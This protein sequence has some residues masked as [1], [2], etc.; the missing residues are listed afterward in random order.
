MKAAGVLS[1][2]VTYVN[3]SGAGQISRQTCLLQCVRPSRLKRSITISD[4]RRWTTWRWLQ[5]PLWL[6]CC[7]M[8]HL[9][10]R[11]MKAWPMA[12]PAAATTT[13]GRAALPTTRCSV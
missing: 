10:L 1:M 8:R 7:Q 11:R 12:T 6:M 2:A 5:P 4:C 13:V 9:R 3:A